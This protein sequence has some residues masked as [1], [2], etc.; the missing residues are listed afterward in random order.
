MARRYSFAT[1]VTHPTSCNTCDVPGF[2]RGVVDVF[3]L[4]R[5]YTAQ[6]GRWIPTFRD[7]SSNIGNQL[8]YYAA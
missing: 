5:R 8:Q 4:L 1:F 6:Y 7:V 2:R 3:A